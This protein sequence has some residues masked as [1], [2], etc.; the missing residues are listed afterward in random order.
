LIF[1]S[2]AHT[3]ISDDENELLLSLIVVDVQVYFTVVGALDTV[4]NHVDE[5][6]LHTLWVTLNLLWQP[7]RLV[8]VCDS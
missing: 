1:V 7:V 3:L 2:D 8:D 4:D 5:D 6:L